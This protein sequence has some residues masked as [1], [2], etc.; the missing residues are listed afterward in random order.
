MP[1]TANSAGGL[2]SL[3]FALARRQM[4]LYQT[5]TIEIWERANNQ[6]KNILHQIELTVKSLSEDD[7]KQFKSNL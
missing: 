6:Q 4:L 5:S 2:S 1:T 3:E 7:I